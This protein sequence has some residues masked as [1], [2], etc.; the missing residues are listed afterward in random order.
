MF[1]LGILRHEKEQLADRASRLS[2]TSTKLRKES[3]AA[4]KEIEEFKQETDVE[5][6]DL[7]DAV[8]REERRAGTA[9][10]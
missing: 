9:L 10:I 2:R 5:K 7:M 8:D 3:I 6:R 1:Q 4:K